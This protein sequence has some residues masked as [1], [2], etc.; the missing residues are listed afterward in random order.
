MV[1]VINYKIKSEKFDPV[2]VD[3]PSDVDETAFL[4]LDSILACFQNTILIR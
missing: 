1:S 3:R 2:I 4:V